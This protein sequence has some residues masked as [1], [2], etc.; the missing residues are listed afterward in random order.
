MLDAFLGSSISSVL[1]CLATTSATEASIKTLHSGK[2]YLLLCAQNT[3]IG[4]REQWSSG[5]T[6]VSG[7]KAPEFDSRLPQIA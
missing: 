2:L 7:G 1:I 3:T 5:K 4:G 6:S